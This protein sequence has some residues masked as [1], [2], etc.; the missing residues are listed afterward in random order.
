MIP[1]GKGL[2]IRLRTIDPTGGYV[3]DDLTS[4][5]AT[6]ANYSMRLATPAATCTVVLR[7]AP[8]IRVLFGREIHTWLRNSPWLA[9][10]SPSPHHSTINLNFNHTPNSHWP[11]QFPN[12]AIYSIYCKFLITLQ[13]KQLRTDQ[14]GRIYIAL[15][16]LPFPPNSTSFPHTIFWG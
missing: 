1:T 16:P 10:T 13:K 15:I 6:A 3:Y 7:P 5:V 4:I 9:G 12:L 8:F 14:P 2:K 11:P